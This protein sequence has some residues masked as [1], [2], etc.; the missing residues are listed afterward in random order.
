MPDRCTD[1]YMDGLRLRGDELADATVEALF[2]DG[3]VGRFNTLM[4]WFTTS[5]QEVPEGL[6]GVARDY[7]RA[8]AMPPDWVD[9]AVMEQAR[10]F[11]ID[12]DVHISTALS[13]AAMPACYVVPHVARLLSATHS[14]AYPSRRMAETGQFTVYLMR[15]DAFEAG[16]RF[17]PAAQKVRLLHASIRRHLKQDDRWPEPVPICQEDMLGGLMMFSLQVL[18]ALHRM[19]V[20]I[21]PDGAEAYYYAW[22]VVGAILG[23]DTA[24]IPPDLPAAREFSD[25]YMVRHMG[26]SPEGAHLTRQLI[27]M[28]EQVVPGTLLDPVVPAL[29]RFLV[30]DTAADWLEVPR[31]RWDS[32]IK[33]A[34]VLL[35]ELESFEDRGPWA[36]QL[37]DRLGYL[38]TMLELSSLTRGRVMHYAVPQE[39]K[40]LYG[41]RPA[42]ARWSPPPPA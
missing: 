9:W 30:G 7:L 38:V 23:C 14:L 17:L 37:A 20:H 31:S 29:I 4:R 41:I 6:P 16:G 13:F 33:V 32:V 10:Q 26:P 42:A 11:F 22:R 34:P 19:G 3:Q 24:D 1:E 12:N 28:Y 5:G 8:T 27:E 25:R 18:D 35:R 21:T 40:P 39:L 2:A 15:P 36:A